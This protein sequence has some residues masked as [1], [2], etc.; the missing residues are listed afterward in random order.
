MKIEVKQTLSLQSP[1]SL[2]V[3]TMRSGV[4]GGSPS[5][6]QTAYRKN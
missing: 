1:T 3:E 6:T 5:T 2:I 4:M